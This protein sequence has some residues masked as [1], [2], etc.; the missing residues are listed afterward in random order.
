M[1]SCAAFHLTD[2]NPGEMP[3]NLRY[4]GPKK[5]YRKMATLT[6]ELDPPLN[7]FATIAILS[8]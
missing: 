2:K 6:A 3:P 8:K 1:V 7:H 4:F 5:P